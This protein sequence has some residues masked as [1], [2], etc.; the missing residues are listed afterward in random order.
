MPNAHNR[1]SELRTLLTQLNLGAMADVFA[2]VA[3]RAAKE[4]LSHEAYLYE[5]V[6]QE[7][8]QRTQRRTARL[9]RASGL[10]IEKTFRTLA[11]GRLS[12]TL[13]LQLE[14]LKS[15]SFLDTAT[16]ILAIGKPGVGKSHCLAAVGY[17]LI[18]A[19]HP[20]LWTSTSTLVQR[21]L[22]AK[23]DLR[24]PQELAK[25]DK[26]ACVILDDIGYVQHDRD[27]ME[28]LFTFL[29]E[30][31]ERKSVM[32]TTNLVFS[33]WER[34]FKDPMTTMAAI[35]RLVHH[36]VIL[37][38]MSV[39]S[40]RAEAA[41]QQ[42]LSSARSKKMVAGRRT[43]LHE[44]TPSLQNFDASCAPAQAERDASGSA[45]AEKPLEDLLI[46]GIKSARVIAADGTV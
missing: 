9:I 45:I 22:A 32:I 13:Q 16:N 8:E 5:L 2:D 39:E 42:H 40:Y 36:S 28:V 19:G 18:Y 37:D 26:F 30:R 15:A 33:E 41:S 44:A 10:P 23:R 21:L 29:A 6:Q 14:R 27:E 35:D 43:T 31:Y 34:I 7:L 12:P 1:H 25:L 11:L 20:V 46:D 38:M 3:L 17:E 4:G 24:L